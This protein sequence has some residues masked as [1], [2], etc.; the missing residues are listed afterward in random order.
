MTVPAK[1]LRDLSADELVTCYHALR[2]VPPN[3]CITGKSGLTMIHE[4]EHFKA[5]YSKVS[6]AIAARR[7]CARFLKAPDV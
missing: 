7:D 2:C 1:P 4:S 6:D 5:L 3:A